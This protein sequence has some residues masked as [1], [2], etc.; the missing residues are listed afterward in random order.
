MFDGSVFMRV[1]VFVCVCNSTVC[2]MGMDIGQKV[3]SEWP[4]LTDSRRGHIGPR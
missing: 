2:L 3:A 4:T 1:C